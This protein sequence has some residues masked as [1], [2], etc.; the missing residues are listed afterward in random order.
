MTLNKISIHKSLDGWDLRRIVTLYFI[1]FHNMTVIILIE[2][3]R[4][5]NLVQIKFRYRECSVLILPYFPLSKEI[6][7]FGFSCHSRAITEGDFNVLNILLAKW[8]T[9]LH[10]AQIVIVF[11]CWHNDGILMNAEQQ[12]EGMLARGW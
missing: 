4:I 11:L 9:A 6:R 1:T 2:K 7:T 12:E 3:G 10:T 5:S 8:K